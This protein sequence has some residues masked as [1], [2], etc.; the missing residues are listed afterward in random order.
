M[1]RFNVVTNAKTGQTVSIAFSPAEEAAVNLAAANAVAA[2]PERDPLAEL[3]ALKAMMVAKGQLTK[4][5][6][7]AIAVAAEV[8]IVK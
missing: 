6:A 7:D 1:T 2:V 5:E 4:S 8:E 3:D